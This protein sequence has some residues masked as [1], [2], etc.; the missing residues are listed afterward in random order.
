MPAPGL[1]VVVSSTWQVMKGRSAIGL[2]VRWDLIDSILAADV[3]AEDVSGIH[4][5]LFSIS[6]HEVD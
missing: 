3:L 6:G 1:P 4:K 2:V 5:S